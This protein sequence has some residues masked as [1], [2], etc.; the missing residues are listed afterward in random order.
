MEL[1]IENLIFLLKEEYPYESNISPQTKLVDCSVD[2]D[3]AI[4]LLKKLEVRFNVS[5][6]NFPFQ[7]YF[8]EEIEISRGLSWFGLKKRREIEDE[9]TVQMLFDYMILHKKSPN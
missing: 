4:D 5:F 6:E 3:D 9:L 2:G 7:K 8:L 1:T